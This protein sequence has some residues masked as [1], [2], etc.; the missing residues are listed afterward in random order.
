MCK[1][2]FET[3]P[4]ILWGL[5]PKW[6]C[7]SYGDSSFNFLRNCLTVF[8]NSCNL[9]H[10]HE[11]CA[12]VLSAPHPHQLLFSVSLIGAILLGVRY[13]YFPKRTF[14]LMDPQQDLFVDGNSQ[15]KNKLYYFIINL[16]FLLTPLPVLC[17]EYLLLMYPYCQD[18]PAP[19]IKPQNKNALKFEFINQFLG[20]NHQAT[21]CPM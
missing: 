9:L 18:Q 5:H 11:Q 21:H 20:V 7:W 19:K 10:S 2:L 1:H 6:D 17:S 8:H 12:R 16:G 15:F 4:S 3:L 13:T 14:F